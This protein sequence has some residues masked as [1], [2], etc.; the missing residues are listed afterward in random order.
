MLKLKQCLA[1]SEK[2]SDYRSQMDQNTLSALLA[3]KM[4][5]DCKCYDQAT[6]S[7]LLQKAKSATME[8][9]RAHSSKFQ[10]LDQCF[11]MLHVLAD[12]KLF[13]F[14]LYS[15]TT[16]AQLKYCYVHSYKLRV[17]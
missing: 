2:S 10:T 5:S 7:D 12:T 1:L 16:L 13:Q 15:S 9:N 11:L 17:L 14:C 4:N 3:C 8:C 6:P